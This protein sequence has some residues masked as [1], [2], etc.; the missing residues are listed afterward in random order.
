VRRVSAGRR[1]HHLLNRTLRD[2]VYLEVGDR[3]GGDEAI[4]PDDDI[5][6]ATL[7]DGSRGFT[8]KDGTP[9]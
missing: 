2:V 8:H 5:Q 1:A 7:P 4:Y 3:P 9:Y 6:A